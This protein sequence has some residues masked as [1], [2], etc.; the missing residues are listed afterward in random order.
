MRARW[1]LATSSNIACREVYCKDLGKDGF[2]EQ[3]K[4]E[5]TLVKG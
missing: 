2:T 1:N 3:V 5:R 4:L